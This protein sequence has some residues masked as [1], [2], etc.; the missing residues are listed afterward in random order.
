MNQG[1]KDW[2]QYDLYLSGDDLCIVQW[3]RL[4]REW[5]SRCRFSGVVSSKFGSILDSFLVLKDQVLSLLYA[6]IFAIYKRPLFGAKDEVTE[7]SCLA[8]IQMSLGFHLF[9][10]GADFKLDGD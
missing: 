2:L 5:H 9:V 7:G 8:C 10:A 4:S 6:E 3:M 1:L